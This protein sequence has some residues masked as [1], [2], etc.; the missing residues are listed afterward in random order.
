MSSKAELTWETGQ[1]LII[2]LEF[3]G[4]WLPLLKEFTDG[5]GELLKEFTE[6]E[7]RSS[8]AVSFFEDISKGRPID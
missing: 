4:E 6:E 7:A 2:T 1:K 5:G 8:F 3:E